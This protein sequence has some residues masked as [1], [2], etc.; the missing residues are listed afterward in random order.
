MRWSKPRR[1]VVPASRRRSRGSLV[2]AVRAFTVAILLASALLLYSA[3]EEKRISIYSNAA[4]YSLPVL[5]RNGDEYIGLLEVFEPLGAVSAKANGFH[6]KFRYYDVESDF[7]AGKTR[8]RIR[9]SDFDLP[10]SFLLENG[11]G[12]VPL[13]CLPTL[14]PRIL[15]GPVTFNQNSR[16]LFVGNVAVHFTAQVSKTT[17]PKLVMNFSAPVNP[18]I[19]TEPGALRMSF[20]HEAVVAPGS[21]ALTFDSK[22]IPSASFQ[23]NNGAAALV[24]TASV[25]LMA[26]FANNGRTII[27]EPLP[28]AVVPAQT[29]SVPRP[30]VT[31]N[32]ASP[33]SGGSVPNIR[34][35]FAVV[36]PSHGG[37]E[38]G[39]S[40]S[41]QMAEKD[42]TLAFARWLRHEFEARGIATLLLRDGD[43]NLSLD[44]RAS[45]TN[46]AHPAIY[47]CVHAASQGNGVRVYAALV[48][49]EAENRGP[50][51]SWDAAQTSYQLISRTAGASLVAELQKKQIPARSLIA[52]LRPLNN[53]GTAAI[54]LEVAPLSDDVSQLNSSTYQQMIAGAVAAGVADARDTLEAGR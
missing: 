15:G 50:F 34:R 4:N 6:W 23:E 47:I 8:A 18:M 7:T 3:P 16:R 39:A 21:Q 54:A 35:Y 9:G 41:G 11:R 38:R 44:Q 25:P 32:I 40:L 2:P 49:G 53:I 5:E 24:V 14:M 51:L 27:V 19:A 31:S 42:V 52:P 36:D 28:Q 45:L 43:N 46:S 26:S 37:D 29:A 30:P 20:N 33:V 12:L 1:S 10:A 22:L 17:P 48:P 13:S